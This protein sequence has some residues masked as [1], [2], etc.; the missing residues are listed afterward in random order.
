MTPRE[1][2]ALIFSNDGEI[3]SVSM[4]FNKMHQMNY[5]EIIKQGSIEFDDET[6]S[7]LA[8]NGFKIFSVHPINDWQLKIVVRGI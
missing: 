2:L 8:K 7:K 6:Q 5:Y 1:R 4:K 3:K